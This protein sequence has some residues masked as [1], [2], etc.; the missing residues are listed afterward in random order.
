MS[1]ISSVGLVLAG[2]LEDILLRTSRSIG[3]IIPQCIVE[4]RVRNEL[5]ITQHPIQNGAP[6][7][8]HAF[9]MPTLV[10]AR[11]GWSNSGA[12]FNITTGGLVSSDPKDIYDQLLTLQ[13]SRQP[14]VLQTGKRPYRNML[15]QAIEQITDKSSE[16]ILSVTITFKEVFIVTVE[17]VQVAAEN[18]A[19]PEQ[20]A[21]VVNKGT[22]QPKPVSQSVLRSAAGA[23]GFGP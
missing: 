2:Q 1:V 7:T 13:A 22:I 23:F 4:E 19:S 21:P 17:D 15:I 6:I 8:D 20:T 10:T 16:N 5:V 9:L 12:I 18:Q 14:F 11:Y 3:T